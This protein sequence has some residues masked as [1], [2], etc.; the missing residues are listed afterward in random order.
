MDEQFFFSFIDSAPIGILVFDSNFNITAVNNNFFGFRGVKKNVPDLLIGKNILTSD[1]FEKNDLRKELESVKDG[2]IF[3]KQ[4]FAS[5]TMKGEKLI[6]L[7]KGAPIFDEDEFL[8]GLLL[9]EDI[10]K[11]VG[12]VKEPAVDQKEY[13]SFLSNISN[14]FA[15]IGP[16]GN[17]VFKSLNDS[18]DYLKSIYNPNAAVIEKVFQGNDNFNFVDFYNHAKGLKTP[19]VKNFLFQTLNQ[20]VVLKAVFVPYLF[21][22]P[23]ITA[24]FIDEVKYEALEAKDAGEEVA[25]LRNY[26]SM[27]SMIVDAVIG[28]DIK[29]KITY[30]NESAQE[31]FKVSKMEI[32]GKFI[33]KIMP[34]FT[35]N[36][37]EK[38]K[39]DIIKNI[40]INNTICYK[41][42]LLL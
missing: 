28:M 17:L 32:F 22:A 41:F 36:Y 35:E 23:Q 29:G 27:T 25:E 10:K 42:V 12:E 37:F 5:K 14:F 38:L 16:T 7:S 24:L 3:E 34:A 4:V 31:L 9:L 1:I 15:I 39:D 33:G 21:S 6:V 40:L 8:G 11:E 20:N 30:W 2:S 18:S 19:L 26:Y 13:Y